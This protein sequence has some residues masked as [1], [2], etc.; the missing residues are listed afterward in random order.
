LADRDGNRLTRVPAFTGMF[1]LPLGGRHAA[2]LLVR[3]VDPRQP[4]QSEVYRPFVNAIDA[5]HV[6][7]R[8]E[9]DVARLLDRR[10]HVDRAVAALQVAQEI[11]AEDCGAAAAIH[12]EI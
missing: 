1:E 2:L 4:R 12:P 9:I 3:Q 6:A 8:V 5:E 7:E 11:A 10:S